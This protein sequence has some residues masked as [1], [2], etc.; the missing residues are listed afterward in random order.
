[1]NRDHGKFID[2]TAVRRR[3]NRL[4]AG[5]DRHAD[6]EREVAGRLLERLDPIRLQP[7]RIVDLG[8]GTGDGASGLRKRFPSAWLYGV[9]FAESMLR[10]GGGK[11]GLRRWLPLW[12]PSLSSSICADAVELPI[13]AQT[14]DLVWSNLLLPWCDAPQRVFSEAHRILRSGGLL[15]FST[16]GPDSLKEIRQA[17]GD[18]RVRF[19]RLADMHDLGDMLIEAGYSDPVIDMQMIRVT[20]QDLGRVFEDLRRTGGNFMRDRPRG[21]MGRRTWNA[22]RAG[23]E[24]EAKEGGVTLELVFG[25]AWKRVSDASPRMG[26]PVRFFPRR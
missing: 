3:F 5:Y 11:M 24:R 19:H 16:L 14:I 8:C 20:Y 13:A 18:G 1:M 10:R 7:Q 25:H 21:M 15:T 23:I 9:D 22:L 2:E 26:V 12:P 4:A 17:F 6:I